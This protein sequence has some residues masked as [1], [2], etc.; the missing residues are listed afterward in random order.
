MNPSQ[1]TLFPGAMALCGPPMPH[2]RRVT[3]PLRQKVKKIT[4]T[5]FPFLA[6]FTNLNREVTT[7]PIFH[8]PLIQIWMGI[9]ILNYSF[10]CMLQ[11]QPSSNYRDTFFFFFSNCKFD[12]GMLVKILYVPHYAE[13]PRMTFSEVREPWGVPYWGTHRTPSLFL[14][15]TSYKL[16]CPGR[17]LASSEGKFSQATPHSTRAQVDERAFSVL[18]ERTSGA[19]AGLN[20]YYA[21]SLPP[22]NLLG[23]CLLTGSVL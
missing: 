5:N 16:L 7:W 11:T 8:C 6:T 22:R 23:I 17:R 15:V 2:F 10:S 19:V 18:P 14:W 9:G 4:E 3:I 13:F 21:L 20:P 1:D 12:F